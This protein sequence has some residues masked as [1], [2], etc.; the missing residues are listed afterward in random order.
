[1]IAFAGAA[2]AEFATGKSI[3]E[4]AAN[5]PFFITFMVFLISLGSL[6]PKYASGVPLVTLLDATGEAA[7]LV[8]YQHIKLGCLDWSQLATLH[9]LAFSMAPRSSK[10][11]MSVK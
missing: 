11:C 10:S 5:S 9:K 8:V 3:F 6:L 4:Q 2:A 1:M 7:A